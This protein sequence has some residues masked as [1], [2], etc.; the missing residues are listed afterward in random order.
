MRKH[1]KETNSKQKKINTTEESLEELER[2]SHFA[3]HCILSETL[4]VKSYSATIP[5]VLKNLA[6]LKIESHTK[7][8]QLF[9]TID[10]EYKA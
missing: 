7:F 1:S 6:T 10:N 5:L 8:T 9:G 2:K 3:L 4:L